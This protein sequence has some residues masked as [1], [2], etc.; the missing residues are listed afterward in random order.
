MKNK[1]I[2]C[3]FVVVSLSLALSAQPIEPVEKDSPDTGL[4]GELKA[5]YDSSSD[6]VFPKADDL[7]A[8]L[9][10]EKSKKISQYFDEA[11]K[12]YE[13]ILG[14]REKREIDTTEKRIGSNRK[15]LEEQKHRLE[16]SESTLQDVKGEYL[17]RYLAL[18]NSHDQGNIDEETYHRELDQLA[19]TYVYQL[20]TLGDDVKFYRS[21]SDKTGSRLQTLEEINRI[22]RILMEQQQ[23]QHSLE[24]EAEAEV[25]AP[26]ARL[27]N[28]LEQLMQRIEASGCFRDRNGWDSPDIN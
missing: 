28:A 4:S 15:L 19:R 7:P 26:P 6:F 22:N 21:E 17:R 10:E 9:D 23:Q 24:A 11:L 20:E 2:L 3:A 12:N 14:G 16:A 13:D 27:P 1:Y 25:E 5:D 18:K 8:P